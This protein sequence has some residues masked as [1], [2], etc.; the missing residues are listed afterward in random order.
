MQPLSGAL[1]GKL[2]HI[3]GSTGVLVAGMEAR[4]VREDGTEA[5]INEAGEL[6]LRGGNVSVGYWNNPKAT[7]EAFV[8]GW[9]HTGDR[10]I[11][12]ENGN[13]WCVSTFIFIKYMGQALVFF[14]NQSGSLIVPR[15]V[16]FD[17]T[18]GWL[19]FFSLIG[20]PESFRCTSIPSRNREL[21]FRAS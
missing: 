15:L 17:S 20:H 6:W 10:F 7:T 18:T 3:P 1:D 21:P 11:I 12:D 2:Q 4:I 13:F 16:D 9:L 19:I 8:D 5:D 14:R